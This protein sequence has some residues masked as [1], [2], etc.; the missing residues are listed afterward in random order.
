MKTSTK[1]TEFKLNLGSQ[2]IELIEEWLETLTRVWNRGLALL[3]WR[4]Y[5]LRRQK[6]LEVPDTWGFDVQPTAINIRLE[7]K[8]WVFYSNI[9]AEFRIDRTKG[10]EIEGNLELRPVVNLVK[11]HWI[12]EPLIDGYSAIAVKKPFAKM[13]ITPGSKE[14]LGDIPII[15]VN[16][17]ISLVLAPAWEQYL[18]GKRKRPNYR[19]KGREGVA[20]IPSESFRGSC[21]LDGDR[22]RLPG[23]GW[24]KV[25][26]LNDRLSKVLGDMQ[27]KLSNDFE[28]ALSIPAIA[29]KTTQ[30]FDK[31]G[32]PKGTPLTVQ[33]AIAHY[34]TPGAF[35]IVRK[36]SGY[37]LQITSSLP[38]RDKKPR[39]EIVALSLGANPLAVASDN[40]EHDFKLKPQTDLEKKLIKLQ[41]QC[42]AQKGRLF[43][44]KPGSSNYKKH[45]RKI[46]RLHEK[47]TQQRQKH[48]HWR[49]THLADIYKTVVVTDIDLEA[50]VSRPDPKISPE[51]DFYLPNGATEKARVN[52]AF[53]Q[54]APGQFRELAK[55]KAEAFSA[56]DPS[57]TKKK[58]EKSKKITRKELSCAILNEYQGADWEFTPEE[59]DTE[60]AMKQEA[61]TV[62]SDQSLTE[63]GGRIHQAKKKRKT[64][65]KQRNVAKKRE[66]QYYLAEP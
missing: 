8:D 61:D 46:A 23:L 13:R 26:G 10:R 41:R 33:E 31:E 57:N 21:T 9:A 14:D 3:E 60:Q 27:R 36:A 62:R 39:R 58:L 54:A 24:I 59:L 45:Q 50:I 56:I 42:S 43:P 48:Q 18:K 66:Q 1:K 49:S 17:F 11:R 32:N 15:Y 22:V 5:Y 52:K 7:G 12:E 29:A 19:R 44:M 53:S 37:Y 28:L 6:C 2:Q 63:P 4:Q 35:A 55:A 34:C 38:S 25:K 51:G 40:E 47:A 64:R 16:D 65:P 30:K 20:T